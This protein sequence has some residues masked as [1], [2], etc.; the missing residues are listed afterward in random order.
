MRNPPHLFA[1]SNLDSQQEC[2]KLH[3]VVPVVW[4]VEEVVTQ[5]IRIPVEDFNKQDENVLFRGKSVFCLKLISYACYKVFY[6][7]IEHK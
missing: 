4:L 1:V 3:S 6:I 7:P 2:I 5:V